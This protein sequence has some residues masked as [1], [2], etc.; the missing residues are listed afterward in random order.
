MGGT[1]ECLRYA[2]G[3]GCPWD[4]ETSYGAAC[5]W[6]LECLRYALEHGCPGAE[7]YRD[8]TM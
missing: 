3:H 4:E 6:H 1:P 8:K 7:Y 5:C 2:H